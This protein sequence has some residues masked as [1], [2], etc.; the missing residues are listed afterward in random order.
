MS[1]QDT[2][3]RNVLLPDIGDFKDVEVIEILVKPGDRI[4]IETPLVTLE[5]DKAVMDIPSPAAGTVREI[6]VAVGDRVSEGALLLVLDAAPAAAQ[7]ETAQPETGRPKAG[8]PAVARDEAGTAGNGAGEQLVTV[9]DI[10]D[11]DSVDVIDILVRPGDV[12]AAETPLVTL[13][14]EKATMDIPSPLAGTVVDLVVSVG[15]KVSMGSALLTVRAD[16]RDA[17]PAR[18]VPAPDTQS[19]APAPTTVVTGRKPPVA[20]AAADRDTAEPAHA[21]PSVRRYARELGVD[22]GQVTGS[23]P[24]GRILREDVQAFVKAR[25]SRPAGADAAA[26]DIPAPA[27]IDFARFGEIEHQPLGK[28][29]RLSGQNLHRAWISIPHVTQFDEADITELEEFRRQNIASTAERGVKLTLLSFLLKASVVVL[30]KFPEFNASLAPGGN[31]LIVKHYYHLGFAADTPEGLLV[32]V[33]RDVDKKGLY[34]IAAEVQELS[35]KARERKLAPAALQGGTFTISSLG[36]VGGTAFTPIINAPEVAILGVSRA[37]TKPVYRD[38]ALAPRLCLPL[39]LSFDHRA[40]DG[41]A[42]ARFTTMLAAVLA[43]IRK[44][45]L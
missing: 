2:S 39:S 34:D 16:V 5:S 18:A 43:D 32:P 4:G 41:V 25:L 7:P 38:G 33:I 30:K 12:V 37:V 14:S 42:A 36:G 17:Q 22:A 35:A 28:I 13:E 29:R 20:P 6:R 27:A 44:V 45:L 15:D 40:V 23:G 10:G 19:V 26:F 21:S 9:P 24:K 11:F 3:A 31:E 8:Q 1:A